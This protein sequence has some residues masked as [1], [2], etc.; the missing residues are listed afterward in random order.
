LSG[1]YLNGLVHFVFHSDIGGTWNGINYNRLNVNSLT[2]QSS[3]YGLQ[4][5]FDYSYPSVSS[6][7]TSASDKSVM[8]GFGRSGSTIHPEVRVV[9]C[10][11]GMS[12][13]PSTL[14]KASSGF[15]S[16]SSPTIERWGDYTGTAR[17]HNS[18]N[19]SIWMNGM[20]GN[21]SNKWD[22][23]IA[24]IHDN[25]AG[26]AE[27]ETTSDLKIYPNPIIETFIVDF[28]LT[29]GTELEINI[30]DISGN[31]V[32]E[33]FKGMANSGENVF[34]FNKAKLSPG[35]YFLIINDNSNTIKNE[36]IIISY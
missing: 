1:F 20:F 29:V 33:L 10:D 18:G 15:V 25:E 8:I 30:I 6:Y 26:L 23:W 3:T 12:W 5:S 2:N 16:Y 36:K 13:S 28:D 32:K 24:E 4:G 9:N 22:T 35:T 27:N 21:N 7:A 19:P 31:V 14:V 17:K 34:S 11:D